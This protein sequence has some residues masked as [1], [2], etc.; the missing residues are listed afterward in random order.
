MLICFVVDYLVKVIYLWVYNFTGYDSLSYLSVFCDVSVRTL[1]RVLTILVCMGLGISCASI[2]E[3]TLKLG[4]FAATYFLINCWDSYVSLNPPVGDL[5]NKIRIYITAG[6]ARAAAV[7]RSMDAMVY[8]WVFQSLMNTMEELKQ[9]QQN[10][11]LAVFTRLY[12]LLLVS[13][14]VSTLTLVVFSY[15]VSHEESGTMWKYQW[16]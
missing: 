6:W 5:S 10:A 12:T 14:V 1:T 16:L 4:V 15:F 2:P 8:F 7:T 3:S 13:V 11:K 9:N